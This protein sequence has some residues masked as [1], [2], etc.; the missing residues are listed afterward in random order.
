MRQQQF[1]DLLLGDAKRQ[2][3]GKTGWPPTA[4]GRRGRKRSSPARGRVLPGPGD[5]ADHPKQRVSFLDFSLVDR[6]GA[7]A[8]TA[9]L[10]SCFF[11]LERCHVDE[12]VIQA[13]GR[14]S[15]CS[16]DRTRAAN[17]D[18]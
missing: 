13:A 1:A 11:L 16:E 8:P 4:L 18:L 15:R 14:N 17:A 7:V 3:V 12:A 6:V 2:C 10:I 9:V 5:G